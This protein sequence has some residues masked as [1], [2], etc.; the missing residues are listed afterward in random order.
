MKNKKD[1]PFF[2]TVSYNSVHHIIHEVP[3]KY[4]EKYGVKPIHN[5]D[6]DK[7]ETFKNMKPGTYS[8]YYEKYTRLG[9]IG[10]DDMRKY[11]L[12]NL[13]CLDDNLGRL[14]D[15]VKEN[16]IDKNTLI[17]YVS[18]NGGSPIT[19]A[20]NAPLA[21]GKYSLWEGGIRVPM[22]MVMPGKVQAGKT[23]KGYVSTLDI[24]PTIADAAGIKLN[25]KTLD[26]KSLLSGKPYADRLLVWRWGNTWAVRKGDWKLTNANESWGK[27]PHPS[28]QYIK[29]ISN[30]LTLKLFN[31]KNDPGERVNMAEKMPGKVTELKKEFDS[32]VKKNSGR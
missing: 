10:V 17:I 5:Y 31:L 16:N 28:A 32:W 11:Y 15:A 20:D 18:D 12:A 13:N 24:L 7:M 2:L 22:A 23:E 6:P 9:V 29:P 21:A 14:L 3:D 1:K 25:D 26:G 27:G 8:A 19:G 30:D 4:L